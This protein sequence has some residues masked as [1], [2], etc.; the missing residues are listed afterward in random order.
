M[1][2][3]NSFDEWF[4]VEKASKIERKSPPFQLPAFSLSSHLKSA[5]NNEVSLYSIME[6]IGKEQLQFS[7]PKF[8]LDMMLSI[9]PGTWNKAFR[10]FAPLP[11]ADSGVL[12]NLQFYTQRVHLQYDKL[13]SSKSKFLVHQFDMRNCI[14]FAQW[15]QYNIYFAWNKNKP[16]E[17]D[18]FAIVAL[19]DSLEK[20]PPPIKVA[21]TL[22]EFMEQ[23]CSIELLEKLKPVLMEHFLLDQLESDEEE[24]EDNGDVTIQRNTINY[25]EPID[26]G[27]QFLPF[28]ETKH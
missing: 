23:I 26:F 3:Q 9:G 1:P 8:Y 17:G 6:Q 24:E 27:L 4:Q 21:N 16:T 22:N 20:C 28:A 13:K 25:K 14:V 7:F 19:L 2:T 15:K 11:D 5:E 18:E 10:I 12:V